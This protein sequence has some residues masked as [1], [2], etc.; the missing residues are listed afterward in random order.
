MANSANK[1]RTTD[2]E[3]DTVANAL[4]SLRISTIVTQMARA[5]IQ[6]IANIF[7]F[8]AVLSSERA[9]RS[10]ETLGLHRVT[11]GSSNF[12]WITHVLSFGIGSS[13]YPLGKG[14]QPFFPHLRLRRLE[15]Y[16]RNCPVNE[17]SHAETMHRE[18]V[19]PPSFGRTTV[20]LTRVSFA[21]IWIAG[22]GRICNRSRSATSDTA[23][24]YLRVPIIGGVDHQRYRL[25]YFGAAMIAGYV[26][27]RGGGPILSQVLWV[28]S[29][30]AQTP[31]SRQKRCRQSNCKSFTTSHFTN[32][33]RSS[34]LSVTLVNPRRGSSRLWP[35]PILRPDGF[36][37]M[38]R[39]LL[40]AGTRTHSAAC[41]LS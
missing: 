16:L 13:V 27:L 35:D 34:R 23:L 19:A 26:D 24:S 4:H 12:V 17:A 36:W 25:A 29:G 8:V 6:D 22:L 15:G 2:P 40:S 33:L 41:R 38:S 1:Q 20:L 11:A 28:Q 9:P 32:H 30:R 31:E 14:R 39:L 10:R 21:D 37:R 5:A 7:R 3:S 18:K